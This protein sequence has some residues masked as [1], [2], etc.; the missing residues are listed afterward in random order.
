MIG[1][2]CGFVVRK[3]LRPFEVFHQ[4]DVCPIRRGELVH[5]ITVIDPPFTTRTS[6]FQVEV[7]V[8]YLFSLVCGLTRQQTQ[9]YDD[10]ND[11][12][13]FG[14]LNVLRW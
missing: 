7:G 6:T 9:D 4:N 3:R 14:Q 10:G 8:L 12:Q 13:W 1:S 5:L 11:S 2:D